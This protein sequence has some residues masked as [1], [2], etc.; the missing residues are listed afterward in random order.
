[1]GSRTSRNAASPNHGNRGF[2]HGL[3][4]LGLLHLLIDAQTVSAESTTG[5]TTFHSAGTAV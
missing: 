5:D 2:P 1:M 4:A 3:E